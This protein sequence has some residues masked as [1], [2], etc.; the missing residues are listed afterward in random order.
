[1]TI[2]TAAI[3]LRKASSEAIASIGYFTSISDNVV[4][5]GNVSIQSHCLIV[6]LIFHLIPFFSAPFIAK[7]TIS[8]IANCQK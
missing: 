6:G 3:V 5:A 8:E 1:M 4:I 7:F 2:S